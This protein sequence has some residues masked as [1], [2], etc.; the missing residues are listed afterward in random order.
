LKKWQVSSIIYTNLVYS[1]VCGA[2]LA[3]SRA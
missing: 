2:G 1:A 3:K